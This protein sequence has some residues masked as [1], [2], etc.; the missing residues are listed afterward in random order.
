VA[1][2]IELTRQVLARTRNRAVLP[3]LAAGL[4]STEPAVRAAAI[5]ATMRRHDRESHTQ[6][7]RGFATLTDDDRVTLRDAYRATPHCAA[8]AL[9]FALMGVDAT[10]CKNACDLVLLTHDFDLFPTLV[11]AAENSSHS[12]A[13]HMLATIT[14]LAEQLH[15][16][17]SSWSV[18]SEHSGPDPSFARHRMLAALERSVL[19]YAEHRRQHILDAF[20]LLA[21]NDNPVL[22]RVLRD[23]NHP[24][25]APLLE[26]LSSSRSTVVM[27]RLVAL[28]RD[29][30]A[31][32][33]ALRVIAQRTDREFV[34]FLLH[35]LKYPVPL[36]VLHNM[37]RLT[38]VAWIESHFKLIL[39]L[40]GRAHAVA[41][42]LATASSLKH[43]SLFRLLATLAR[44]GLA[45]GRRAACH[46]LAK[47][48]NPEAD[49]L[50]LTCIHDPDAGV[51]AA[52]ALQLR[53][54]RLP[55]ALKML[56][57]LLDSPSAEVRDAARSSLAEFNFVRYRAMFDLLDEHAI[58]NTGVLVHKVDNS[59]ID[60]LTKELASPS[61]TS[62]LR[63]IE[64]AVAMDAAQ[65][66]CEPLIELSRHENI[67]VRQAAFAA[68]RHCTGPR[69]AQAFEQAAI[70]E[71]ITHITHDYSP[72]LR[73]ASPTPRMSVQ[74][75]VGGGDT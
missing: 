13:D 20:L 38:S 10:L 17:L 46:A 32:A 60:G 75:T 62:R 1:K 25:H 50:I 61:L 44:E 43:E 39:D 2:G 28:L 63:G 22:Q 14:S 26:S 47:F 55:N 58:K 33:A 42:D 36:R 27:E 59:A 7:L 8:P 37:K 53:S 64:M 30:D 74:P 21:P 4:R 24:S 6:W 35:E 16:E 19:R 3:M 71:S 11:K 15:E 72:S 45:E 69:V 66:V 48:E 67:L 18:T 65:E 73:P 9:K 52:A 31:P 34:R 70:D 23:P 29:T 57:H 54:R 68:L 56:V 41:V 5:R 49:Q 12:L 51:Q 40:D